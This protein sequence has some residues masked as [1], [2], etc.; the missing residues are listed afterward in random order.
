MLESIM[1]PKEKP[2]RKKFADTKHFYRQ[3]MREKEEK[4]EWN[5]MQIRIIMYAHADS[6]LTAIVVTLQSDRRLR[7]HINWMALSMH[8]VCDRAW[9]WKFCI[10]IPFSSIHIHHF[11]FSRLISLANCSTFKWFFDNRKSRSVRSRRWH[12]MQIEL[13]CLA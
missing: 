4:W 11:S 8:N 7:V 2:R 12:K 10:L 5:K 3:T 1:K 6:G 13:S 9:M